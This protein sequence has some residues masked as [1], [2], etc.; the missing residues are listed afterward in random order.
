MFQEID[1]CWA[2]WANKYFFVVMDGR[3]LNCFTGY[4][5]KYFPKF[6]IIPMKPDLRK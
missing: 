2:V 3:S 6:S 4:V 5:P 1:T